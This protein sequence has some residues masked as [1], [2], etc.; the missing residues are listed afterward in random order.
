MKYVRPL[1]RAE[2]DFLHARTLQPE[3]VYPG[4]F[5]APA[6]TTQHLPSHYNT[7]SPERLQ[8]AYE[9][10]GW[11]GCV[12]P[13][14]TGQPRLHHIVPRR[15]G[16]SDGSNNLLPICAAHEAA[17]H[18]A[19]AEYRRMTGAP[20]GERPKRPGKKKRLGRKGKIA[21]GIPP[22]PRKKHREPDARTVHEKRNA[23]IIK[24]AANK[25]HAAL[26]GF[27]YGC[28]DCRFEFTER[29]PYCG[30]C[31]KDG[32]NGQALPPCIQWRQCSVRRGRF[33]I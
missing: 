2:R 18:K 14:C 8:R 17:V 31:K 6:A 1:T 20:Y 3:V 5:R 15:E 28:Y 13:D 19:G 32:K 26:A 23:E 27:R 9:Y 30:T 22:T 7:P 12:V 16:G 24:R 11:T 29:P 21:A 25:S 10:W 33:R 4:G